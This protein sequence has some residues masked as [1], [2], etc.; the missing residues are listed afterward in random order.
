MLS[1]SANI[2]NGNNNPNFDLD[3]RNNNH[4]ENFINTIHFETLKNKSGDGILGEERTFM[5]IENEK[6]TS[7]NS[8]S[9]QG[10]IIFLIISFLGSDYYT[11]THIQGV[12]F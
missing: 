3:D 2:G 5:S 12:S 9:L 10:N 1:Y 8:P 11:Y 6:Q 7:P 4:N